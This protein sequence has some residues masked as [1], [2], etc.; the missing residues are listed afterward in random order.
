MT[1]AEA[2]TETKDVIGTIQQSLGT[3]QEKHFAKK[4]PL[5]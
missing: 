2:K 4:E 5:L 1:A 3:P